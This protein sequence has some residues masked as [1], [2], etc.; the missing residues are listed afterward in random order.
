M[1]IYRLLAF[2]V[3]P[4]LLI[5]IATCAH[6]ASNDKRSNAFSMR[7]L[8]APFSLGEE[9]I[10]RGSVNIKGLINAMDL[11][12]IGQRS[13][14]EKTEEYEQRV[15]KF[16]F[17]GNISVESLI[18]FA[19]PLKN[20]RYCRTTYLAD[21]EEYALTCD[22]DTSFGEVDDALMALRIEGISQDLGTY[23]ATNG[24]NK[25]V[26]IRRGAV[27]RWSVRIGTFRAVN[28][29]SI[30]DKIPI[31]RSQAAGIKSR[32]MIGYVLEPIAP[33]FV[34]RV[35]RSEPSTEF[36]TDFMVTE[37]GLVAKIKEIWVFDSETAKVHKKYD[38]KD[39]T[40]IYR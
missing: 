2:H 34:K 29:V 40:S 3:A 24:F 21:S 6:A 1:T 22:Y 16:R 36:P 31:S 15:Q 20:N 13:E 26:T 19:Q 23:V 11:A 39:Y 4:T 30:D 35:W 12:R 32:M 7:F 8:D 33:F 5:F 9:Q 27:Q 14:F 10:P 38:I 37:R 17:A 18:F 25:K 28:A